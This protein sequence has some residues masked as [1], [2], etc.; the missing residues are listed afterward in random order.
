MAGRAF[1]AGDPSAEL[2]EDL[3]ALRLRASGALRNEIAFFT[4]A[5]AL[6]DGEAQAAEEAFGALI[7]LESMRTGTASFNR[8]KVMQDF[9]AGLG[10]EGRLAMARA[11]AREYRVRLD[12]DHLLK[13][14]LLFHVVDPQGLP[15]PR[16]HI[17]SPPEA[18]LLL[19]LAQETGAAV[20]PSV[21]GVA[22]FFH[23]D[24]LL[25]LSL[26]KTPAEAG[27]PVALFWGGAAAYL[28]R[29]L[30]TA[31]RY[32]GRLKSSDP[33]YRLL[34]A[35]PWRSRWVEVQAARRGE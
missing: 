31:E 13:S 27:D 26:L 21:L 28:T 19:L 30:T 34:D 24:P 18:A 25:A 11:Y 7:A 22:W 15:R 2:L 32:W 16:A 5:L 35:Q 9:V 12:P 8:L 1:L 23:G 20:E 6:R 3:A 29:D 10:P 33:V 14:G 17:E 4:G